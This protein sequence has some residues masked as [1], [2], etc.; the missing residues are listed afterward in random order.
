[1]K[2]RRKPSWRVVTQRLARAIVAL[3]R[4][5]PGGTTWS[6]SSVSSWPMS[7]AKVA[8]LA[9]T[10]PARSTTADRST[11]P[12]S[13]VPSAADSRGTI[14]SIAAAYDASVARSSAGVRVPGAARSRPIATRSA[15]GQSTRPWRATCS[16]RRPRTVAAAPSA[17]PTRN[18]ACQTRSSRQAGRPEPVRFGAVGRR[19]V[20][21]RRVSCVMTDI[22]ACRGVSWRP[23]P[24]A[25]LPGG[26]SDGGRD[27][28]R[29]DVGERL[30]EDPLR[31]RPEGADVAGRQLAMGRRCRRRRRAVGPAI[32]A[33]A[34]RLEPVDRQ[35][36]DERRGG[37]GR[38]SRRSR[39]RPR[40]RRRSTGRSSG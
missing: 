23:R 26:S 29:L 31:D 33:A 37:G 6:S 16:A 10:Q 34:G 24:I 30:A 13:S 27:L 5:P 40:R 4:P 28:D 14:R 9:W 38:R 36:L 8:T 17:E 12:G 3:A 22:V 2:P 32:V 20:P 25:R 18:P 11:T 15:P 19:F 39:R 21:E 1:M 7:W 35:Q